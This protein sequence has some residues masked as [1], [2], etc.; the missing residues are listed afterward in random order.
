MLRFDN[1]AG[2]TSVW[3]GLGAQRRLPATSWSVTNKQRLDSRGRL[4]CNRTERQKMRFGDFL[5]D[6]CTAAVKRMAVI[7]FVV[8]LQWNVVAAASEGG[9]F[10]GEAWM[11]AQGSPLDKCSGA[12][13]HDAPAGRHC[14][15]VQCCVLGPADDEWLGRAIVS[16]LV[17]A[18]A[19]YP[20]DRVAR[21]FR[22]TEQPIKAISAFR[23]GSPRSPPAAA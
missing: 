6:R 2:E 1:S 23:V 10:S 11:S 5:P 7:V 4:T 22:R 9:Q 17:V 19:L 15:H 13:A 3:P 20:S 16:V 8:L 12:G 18:D 14:R 21:P